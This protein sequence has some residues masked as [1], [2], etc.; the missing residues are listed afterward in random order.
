VKRSDAIHQD[1]THCAQAL[2]VR[3]EKSLSES[4]GFCCIKLDTAAGAMRDR[5]VRSVEPQKTKELRCK[6]G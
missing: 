1:A 2:D 5:A 3:R 6:Q 4:G